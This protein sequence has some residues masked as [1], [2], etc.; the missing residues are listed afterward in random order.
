MTDSDDEFDVDAMCME[1]LATSSDDE[2]AVEQAVLAPWQAAIQHTSS[3]AR[4]RA[5][6]CAEKP[7]EEMLRILKMDLVAAPSFFL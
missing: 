3:L 5:A 4:A 2:E 6:A 7:L 1:P